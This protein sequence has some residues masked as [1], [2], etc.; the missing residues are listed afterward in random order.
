M[1]NVSEYVVAAAWTLEP[2]SESPR[3]YWFIASETG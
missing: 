3:C 1:G 2:I